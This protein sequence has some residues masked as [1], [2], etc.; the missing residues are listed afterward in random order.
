MPVPH[1]IVKAAKAWATRTRN[2]FTSV[3]PRATSRQRRR[4]TQRRF[5]QLET[6]Y[7]F[8]TMGVD[9]LEDFEDGSCADHFA[10]C[11]SRPNERVVQGVSHGP[12]S[13]AY[14]ITYFENES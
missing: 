10:E 6:R 13:R 4:H 14:E 1:S 12:G 3:S 8:S 7:A 9:I 11:N 5:E 2:M